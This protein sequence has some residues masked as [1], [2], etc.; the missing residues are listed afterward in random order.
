MNLRNELMRKGEYMAIDYEKELGGVKDERFRTAYQMEH[1]AYNDITGYCMS[2]KFC[3]DYKTEYNG[4]TLKVKDDEKLSDYSLSII[5]ELGYK[6]ICSGEF[7]E[8]MYYLFSHNKELFE[9]RKKIRAK[10]KNILTN[11]IWVVDIDFEGKDKMI[12]RSTDIS[13][14][15][16]VKLE[17]LGWELQSMYWIDQGL[18]NYSFKKEGG[19]N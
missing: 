3:I 18:R 5:E 13:A 15:D 19:Y 12:I 16:L 6:L 2:G 14:S 17:K 10:I 1:D 11:V 7:D 9:V 4:I 8:H